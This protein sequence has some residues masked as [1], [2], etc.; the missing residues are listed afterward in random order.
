METI[1]G[2]GQR[3]TLL[4]IILIFLIIANAV[5]AADVKAVV[6]NTSKRGRRTFK[7]ARAMLRMTG[8]TSIV[9]TVIFIIVMV[10]AMELAAIGGVSA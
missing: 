7:R 9:I 8:Y 2:I 4:A 3:L 6:K 10:I 1:I 5:R